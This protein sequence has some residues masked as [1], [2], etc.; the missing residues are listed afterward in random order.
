MPEYLKVGILKSGCIGALPLL[1]FLLDERAEREDIDVRVLGSGAKLGIE[2]CRDI[3]SLMIQQKPDLVIFIGPSQF[4]SG[5]T[6]T[7]KMLANSGIPTVII[8][9]GPTKKIIEQIKKLNLG[10]LIIDADSM[11]GARREFLD[12]SEMAIYNSDIIKVLAVTGT[13]RL[14]MQEIDKIIDSLKSGKKP[15]LP[16]IIVDKN[17]AIEAAG[18]MNPYAKAKAMAAYEISKQVSEI[19]SEACF[20]IK[21]WE[22]YTSL[23]AVGHEMMRN[24]AKL[25]EEAREIEKSC[26]TILRVPHFNNGTLGKKRPLIKKPEKNN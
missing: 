14:I 11:I 13:L 20:K 24:A 1:E 6:E 12:S 7:R 19:N 3:T 16:S 8:S 17:I 26:D 9:D 18:F 21:D 15:V 2:Q 4:S 22:C 10:Y 5:P 23:V 25:S